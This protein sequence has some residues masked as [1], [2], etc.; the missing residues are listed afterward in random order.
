MPWKWS[1]SKIIF[2]WKNLPVHMLS[3]IRMSPKKGMTKIH[4]CLHR[5]SHACTKAVN[6]LAHLRNTCVADMYGYPCTN[7]VGQ[8]NKASTRTLHTTFDVAHHQF[9]CRVYYTLKHHCIQFFLNGGQRFF[10]HYTLWR[11]CDR[12]RLIMKSKVLSFY[13]SHYYI[14]FIT[15]IFT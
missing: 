14:L 11:V 6:A 2:P 13:L 15:G 5:H 3:S 1:A 7:V 9:E 12:I 8:E 10:N 4:H